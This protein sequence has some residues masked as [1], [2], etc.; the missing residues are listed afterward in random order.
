MTV[1]LC[2]RDK[3]AVVPA[4]TDAAV[5]SLA[6]ETAASVSDGAVV[7]AD[8]TEKGAQEDNSRPKASP[9]ATENIAAAFAAARF[10]IEITASD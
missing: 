4:V 8:G 2:R 1:P 9:M 5:V 3:E 6:E 7:E 10:C